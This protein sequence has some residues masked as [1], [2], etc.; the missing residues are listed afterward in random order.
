[1]IRSWLAVL[2]QL[3]QRS[4]TCS[5]PEAVGSSKAKEA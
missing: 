2:S 5:Y 3:K 1:V 4:V